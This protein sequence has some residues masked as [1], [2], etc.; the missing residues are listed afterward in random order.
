MIHFRG[1]WFLTKKLPDST[2][3]SSEK[4]KNANDTNDKHLI[5][6]LLIS[7]SPLLKLHYFRDY[8][9]TASREDS[10]SIPTE[11]HHNFVVTQPLVLIRLV[12]IKGTKHNQLT[13]PSHNK[14]LF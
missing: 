3:C 11:N 13:C 4:R 2:N 7:N 14:I 5:L 10:S 12:R 8:G 6:I 1:R 9:V